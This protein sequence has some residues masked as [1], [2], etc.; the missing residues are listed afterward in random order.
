[1]FFQ[2]FSERQYHFDWR[3]Q[4]GCT[5]TDYIWIVRLIASLGFTNSTEIA[6]SIIDQDGGIKEQVLD[7]LSNTISS[8]KF[9]LVA[10]LTTDQ[11]VTH[12][13]LLQSVLNYIG[14]D[15]SGL[16]MAKLLSSRAA[17]TRSKN[18]EQTIH[19]KDS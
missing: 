5:R 10:L 6:K 17:I 15:Y 4:Y 12:R 16:I 18:G 8:N 3:H 9:S 13:H 7:S 2:L 1:M 14:F 19:G 11:L